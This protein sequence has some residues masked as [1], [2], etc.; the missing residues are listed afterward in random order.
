MQAAQKTRALRLPCLASNQPLLCAAPTDDHGLWTGSAIAIRVVMAFR[1]AV[2]AQT[3]DDRP[4]AVCSRDGARMP[5]SATLPQHSAQLPLTRWSIGAVGVIGNGQLQVG[6]DI[7]TA[8]RFTPRAVLPSVTLTHDTI[9]R[10]RSLI[11]RTE[12][13]LPAELI[14]EVT[15]PNVPLP[16]A[17]LIGRGSGLTPTG[18]DLLIGILAGQHAMGHRRGE[19]DRVIRA[20]LHTTTWLSRNLLDLALQHRFGEPATDLLSAL[21]SSANSW[22]GAVKAVQAIGHTSGSALAVGIAAGILRTA[23]YDSHQRKGTDD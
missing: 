23:T 4:V 16:V 13:D 21:P 7:F 14:A 9:D 19:L 12:L 15:D 10:L 5:F 17:G 18:D 3:I 6:A 1:F 8:T 2:Y 22:S 20:R 11:D